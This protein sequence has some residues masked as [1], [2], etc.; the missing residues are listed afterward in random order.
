MIIMANVSGMDGCMVVKNRELSRSP[1]Y[2][3]AIEIMTHL[4]I[5]VSDWLTLNYRTLEDREAMADI[6]KDGIIEALHD[7]EY[8]KKAF[9]LNIHDQS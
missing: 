7:E 8:Y 2:E 4:A 1:R 5:N 9:G 6:L 3:D